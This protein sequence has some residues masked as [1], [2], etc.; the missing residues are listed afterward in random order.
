MIK[1]IEKYDHEEKIK[2]QKIREC[3]E[4]LKQAAS[5]PNFD[6]HSTIDINEKE[7]IS[8]E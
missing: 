2:K 5:N 8:C 3:L 6:N 4:F 7:E 1:F